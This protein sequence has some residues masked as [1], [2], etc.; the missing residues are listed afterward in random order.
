[1]QKIKRKNKNLVKK[2][3]FA[4]LFANFYL[5]VKYKTKKFKN[6]NRKNRVLKYLQNNLF[7]NHTNFCTKKF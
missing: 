4:I 3:G 7:T 2:K 6:Q 5:F 1:M